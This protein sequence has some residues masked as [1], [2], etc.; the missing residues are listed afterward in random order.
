MTW[1]LSRDQQIALADAQRVKSVLPVLTARSCGSAQS[2]HAVSK[3]QQHKHEFKDWPR[4]L[5][6]HEGARRYEGAAG[7]VNIKGKPHPGAA[8]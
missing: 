7:T 1:H 2:A 3:G 6:L 4:H 8:Q 5:R